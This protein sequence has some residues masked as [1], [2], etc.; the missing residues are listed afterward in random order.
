MDQVSWQMWKIWRHAI[1][2]MQG[3]ECIYIYITGWWFQ[4]WFWFSIIYGMSSFPLTFIF[5]SEGLVYHQPDNI[6]IY[7][8]SLCYIH[9]LDITYNLWCCL[10]FPQWEIHH[11]GHNTRIVRFCV[12]L[13]CGPSWRPSVGEIASNLLFGSV[14]KCWE[15]SHGFAPHFLHLNGHRFS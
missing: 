5:F 1:R 10:F 11:F 13:V 7:I 3:W 12:K 15:G 14:W 2:R 9:M 4:T 6:Y 8:Y